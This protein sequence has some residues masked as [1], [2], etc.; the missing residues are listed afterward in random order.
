MCTSAYFMIDWDLEIRKRFAQPLF[1]EAVEFPD[2]ESILAR[3]LPICYEEG[4]PAGCDNGCADLMN[5]ATE[6]YV[7]ELISNILLR[8]RSNGDHY[9]KTAAYQQQLQREEDAWLKG[10]VAR[11]NGGLLP[12][13][14]MAAEMRRPLEIDDMRLALCLGDASIGQPSLM[15]ERLASGDHIKTEEVESTYEDHCSDDAGVDSRNKINISSSIQ[16]FTTGDQIIADFASEWPG[17]ALSDRQAL[18]VVLDDCL[19]IG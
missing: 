18:S 17:S 16:C 10:A 19:S 13:E 5:V 11:S 14:A 9:I 6:N 12:V 2:P 7:K 1:S 15:A 3:M 4:I 8:I